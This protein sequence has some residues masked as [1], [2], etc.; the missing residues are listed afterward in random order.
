MCGKKR[1]FS[2]T[3]LKLVLPSKQRGCRHKIPKGILLENRTA[4]LGIRFDCWWIRQS[5]SPPDYDCNLSFHLKLFEYLFIFLLFFCKHYL[6]T[7]LEIFFFWFGEQ[8]T[9]LPLASVR[10]KICVAYGFYHWF[11]ALKQSPTVGVYNINKVRICRIQSRL[12]VVNGKPRCS[13]IQSF[14]NYKW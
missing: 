9:R 12:C 5:K 7:F 13:R 2:F 4:G 6:C 10:I 14:L 8:T 1:K 11:T 3:W